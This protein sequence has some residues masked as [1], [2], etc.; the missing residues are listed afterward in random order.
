MLY[1]LTESR[2]TGA[3]LP[4][5]YEKWLIQRRLEGALNKVV[6]TAGT[7]KHIFGSGMNIQYVSKIDPH[8]RHISN[9][10]GT[11]YNS[12]VTP[13]YLFSLINSLLCLCACNYVI[14][15]SMCKR[16]PVT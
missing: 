8:L 12:S 13:Q 15:D 16:I 11:I 6:I 14:I 4:T 5:D 1:T 7:T 10:E 3:N 2:V 9:Y